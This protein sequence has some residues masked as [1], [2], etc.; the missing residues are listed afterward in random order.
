MQVVPL[1]AVHDQIHS[2]R[3]LHVLESEE[4]GFGERKLT[5]S[6]SMSSQ[7]RVIGKDGRHRLVTPRSFLLTHPNDPAVGNHVVAKVEIVAVGL[8]R[9][10]AA[11]AGA[12][13]Q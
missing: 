1:A 4:T 2:A 3:Q 5:S 7:V 8:H 10:Y 12:V 6:G 9:P 13:N 11:G